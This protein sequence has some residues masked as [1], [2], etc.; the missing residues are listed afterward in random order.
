VGLAIEAGA[1]D[2]EQ[3][4]LLPY[5]KDEYEGFDHMSDQKKVLLFRTF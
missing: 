1:I 3:D 2:S 5:F 4:L